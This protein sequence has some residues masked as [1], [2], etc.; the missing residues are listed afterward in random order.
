MG[1]QARLQLS[2]SRS[3]DHQ[4]F[5]KG[6]PLLGH[7]FCRIKK[8]PP[9]SLKKPHVQKPLPFS[10]YILLLNQS[11]FLCVHCTHKLKTKVK[12][13]LKHHNNT[14]YKCFPVKTDEVLKHG[15][16]HWH[17]GELWIGFSNCCDSHETHWAV[18]SYSKVCFDGLS[19]WRKNNSNFNKES[20]Q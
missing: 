12:Q 16:P 2:T 6:P 20:S 13:K 5:H 1:H 4:V 18:F 8:L 9:T 11:S 19:H 7:I 15:I 3:L 17:C 10:F 14:A